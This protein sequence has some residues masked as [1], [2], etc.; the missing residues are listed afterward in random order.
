MGYNSIVSELRLKDI[1]KGNKIMETVKGLILDQNQI[2]AIT[3]IFHNEM[4]LALAEK[5]SSLQMENTYIP[6]LPDGTEEGVFL[7][8]DLGGTNFR[9]ILLEFKEGN[10]IREEFQHYHISDELRLGCGIELFDFLAECL[11]EFVKQKHLT[12]ERIPLGFTFSFP[13][14]QHSLQSASLITWT[15]SFNCAGVA[16]VDVVQLLRDS[17]HRLGQHNIEVLA[18]INDTTGTLIQGARLDHKTRIGMI[19]GTGSNACYMERA[20]RVKHWE[21]ERHGEQNVIID[22]EWGAFGDNGALDF[23]KTPFDVELDANSLLATSF[24]FEKYLG[25]KYLG[26]LL[27]IVMFDLVKMKLLLPNA[28]MSLFPAPWK[29][30]SDNISFIEHDSVEL[31]TTKT[32]YILNRIGYKYNIDYTEEDIQIIKYLAGLI[33]NRAARLVAI[34]TSVLLSRMSDN[35]ITIAI[36]GSVYKHHPRLKK[37]IEIFTREL[38]P[39]K[40]FH[41]M[42]TEDGSG[43]G[44]ALAAAI[45]LR[46]SKRFG[47][48][49]TTVEK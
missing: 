41:L 3:E 36:D 44:A 1:Q 20:D 48:S 38:I 13:M 8:L 5:Q 2:Q 12:N 49:T 33:S 31:S 21:T 28:P 32:Q 17:L 26:E 25:G 30:P 6:E 11:I 27:R 9:V 18:I 24:T 15:K 35:D 7:A 42:L 23:I 40:N 37:W 46:L 29:F 4:K 34:C 39:T 19:I 45:A 16:N 43:K 14:K 22:I 47:E 10:V